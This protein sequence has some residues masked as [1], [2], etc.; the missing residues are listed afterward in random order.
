MIVG[1]GNDIY[2]MRAPL[3]NNVSRIMWFV[4]LVLRFGGTLEIQADGHAL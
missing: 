1:V 2:L 4:H 3:F